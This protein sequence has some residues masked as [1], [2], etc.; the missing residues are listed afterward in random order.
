MSNP[1]S[2]TVILTF[3]V[4]AILTPVVAPA[5]RYTGPII[6][7][8]AHSMTSIDF[9]AGVPNPA[10]KVPSPES[11]EAHMRMSL[12]VMARYGVVL[13]AVSGYSPE[14]VTRWKEAAPDRVVPGIIFGAPP[15]ESGGAPEPAMLE[16]AIRSGRIRILG[17]VTTQY[18]G[19]SPSDARFAQ[20]WAVAEAAG[21]PVGIHTGASFPRTP[22]SGSPGFRLRLGDPLLLEDMLVRFP[23]LKVYV[24]H[25]GGQYWEH[26]LDLMEMYPQVHADLSVLNWIPGSTRGWLEDLIP[27]AKA[28]GL[29]GR[30]M[31]GS[32]QMLWPDAI[33]LAV[34]G[35]NSLDMLTLEEKRGIFYDNA[36]RFLGLDDATRKAHWEMVKRER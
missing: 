26:L 20:V 17:E 6:D 36:A 10:S 35:I 21:I 18:A 7:M 33:G 1:V 13:A 5:Q 15:G 32:D 2:S 22:Y 25:A 24:M 12:E 19:Y 34:E 30:F 14:G 8:H 31:F 11:A 29:L 27:E 16:E 28:R 4:T 9:A 3:A 23:D